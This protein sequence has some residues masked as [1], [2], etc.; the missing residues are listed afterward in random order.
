MWKRLYAN[1]PSFLSDF[2]ETWNFS[3]D[4]PKTQTSNFIKIR[5]V[6][7]ELFDADGQTDM[8]KL[9]V[10]IRN[11]TDVPKN[12]KQAAWWKVIMRQEKLKPHI[13]K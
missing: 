11:F 12:I 1:Y 10:A 6:G 13:F 5:P 7:A 3:T 8:M 2:N 4:F 9:T